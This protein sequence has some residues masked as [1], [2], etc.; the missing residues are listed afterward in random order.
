L[1]NRRALLLVFAGASMFS[2]LF[3]T[4]DVAAAVPDGTRH[5]SDAS[6][7]AHDDEPGDDADRCHHTRSR[8]ACDD[9]HC[10][11]RSR[12]PTR[13]ET[14]VPSPKPSA[15]PA[16]ASTAPPVAPRETS[17]PR[18]QGSSPR[19]PAPRIARAPSAAGPRP[20]VLAPPPLTIPVIGPVIAGSKGLWAGYV[21]ALSTVLVAAT[22]AVVSL[23]LVRRSG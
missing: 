9:D 3:G 4:L 19:A 15:R 5:C 13:P 6:P 1:L 11:D 7:R 18:A 20:P 14:A 2:I 12:R 10:R 21:I 8:D 22:I 16:R 17:L 23:V